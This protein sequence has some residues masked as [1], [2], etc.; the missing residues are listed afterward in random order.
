[1]SDWD[2]P[3]DDMPRVYTCAQCEE[4][5]PTECTDKRRGN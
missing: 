5:T 2:T 3:V 4:A 1:M